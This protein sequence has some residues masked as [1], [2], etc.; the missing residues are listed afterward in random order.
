MY[1]KKSHHPRLYSEI[2]SK[3]VSWILQLKKIPAHRWSL[4]ILWLALSVCQGFQ[5]ER[6]RLESLRKPQE[7]KSWRDVDPVFWG[8]GLWAV[9]DKTQGERQ[10]SKGKAWRCPCGGCVM[11]FWM[12]PAPANSFIYSASTEASGVT[13]TKQMMWKEIAS[14][15]PQQTIRRPLPCALAPHKPS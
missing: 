4:P 8:R 13:T 3:Y 2:H 14:C 10:D 5:I 11:V 1:L 7:K 9:W 6:R 12:P 15:N